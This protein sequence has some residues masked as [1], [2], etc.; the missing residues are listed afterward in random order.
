MTVALWPRSFE[1][2]GV[3]RAVR[4][5]S[6]AARH[7]R[8]VVHSH[9]SGRCGNPCGPT[10]WGFNEAGLRGPENDAHGDGS[11]KALLDQHARQS[12]V[13]LK[14]RFHTLSEAKSIHRAN[15]EEASLA[16]SMLDLA[17]SSHSEASAA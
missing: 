3:A 9:K 11:T 16:G 8:T 15:P 12:L 10:T 6:L 14:E 17:R 4:G 5:N 13:C 7:A 2:D 1:R